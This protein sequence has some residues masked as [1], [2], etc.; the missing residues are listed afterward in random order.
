MNEPTQRSNLGRGLAA[1]FGEEDADYAALDRVRATKDVPIEHLHPNPRQPRQR[2]NEE[3]VNELAESIRANGILQPILVRRHPERPAEYE[4]VAGERR[5]RA[6]QSARLHTV[7]VVIRE[8]DDGLALELALVENLQREDLSPLEEAEAYHHLIERFGHTQEGLGQSVGKSRSHIANT[9]RLRGLP[10]S[11]KAMLES[12]ELSAGHA[13]ALLGAEGA[14]ELAR[15]AVDKQLNVRQVERLVQQGRPQKSGG[16]SNRKPRKAGDEIVKDADTLAL[17]RD[18]SSLLGLRV[19]I[20]LKGDGGSLTIHYQTLEQ[21]DDVL[22]R[23]NQTPE[24]AAV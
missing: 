24:P 9:L 4:I 20:A 14:E 22:R 1:L 17:E 10:D 18:L 12:G 19:S 6:A 3:S 5:W 8:V 7:P 23:L 13:R 21:L 2:F 15:L 16:R 11:V